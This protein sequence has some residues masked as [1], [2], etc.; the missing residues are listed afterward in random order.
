VVAVAVS[1]LREAPE[2]DPAAIYAGIMQSHELQTDSLLIVSDSVLP[3]LH[4]I[5]Q[6]YELEL[7]FSPEAA[8]N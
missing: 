4:A 5:P 1:L 2:E 3:A 6:L 7:E 8:P